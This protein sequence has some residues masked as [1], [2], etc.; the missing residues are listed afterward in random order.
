MRVIECDVCGEV[1]NAASDDELAKRLVEHAEHAHPDNV[2]AE[3][4][5]RSVVAGSAYEATDS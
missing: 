5:A 2:P 1:V 3:D 4:A